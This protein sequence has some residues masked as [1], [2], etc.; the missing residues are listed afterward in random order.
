LE[1]E[2][3]VNLPVLGL[4]LH[5]GSPRS[6]KPCRYSVVVIRNGK[7]TLEKRGVQLNEILRIASELG[8]CIL[9]TDNVFE[10]APDVSGLR[11]LFLKLPSGAKIIQVNK[12]GAFFERLSHVAR[13]EGLIV[14]KRSDSLVEAKLAALLA[15]RGVGSEVILFE[16]ECR[17]VVT[18]N[19]SIKKGGSGTN[20]WRRMIEAA[21]LNE[22]NRI[23]SCLDERG[24][25]YDLYVHQAEGGLRRAEFVVYAPE[26]TVTE[27]VRPRENGSIKV[28]ITRKMKRKLEFAGSRKTTQSKPL[29]VSIDPGASLG[30]AI[31]D[32]EGNVISLQTLRMPSR[33]Q[34]IE[35]IVKHGRPVLITTDVF[36]IPERVKEIA[37]IF[38]AKIEPA[39]D[40][41]TLKEKEKVVQEFEES[42]G[43]KASTSHERDALAALLITYR[44]LNTL[45]KKAEARAR[46]KGVPFTTRVRELL[47]KG[48]SISEALAPEEKSE[49]LE[50]RRTVKKIRRRRSPI[51]SELLKRIR[52]LEDRLSYYEELLQKKEKEISGLL[53]QISQLREKINL[54]IERDRRIAQRDARIRELEQELRK[55]RWKNELLAAKVKELENVLKEPPTGW[56]QVLVLNKLSREV[57]EVAAAEKRIREGDVLLVIDAS[58]MGKTVVGMLSEL[59][60]MALIW[61]RNPPPVE[62]I[63]ELESRGINV[64]CG[65]DIEIWWRGGIPY[66]KGDI[67]MRDSTTPEHVPK[68]GGVRLEDIL[69][70]YRSRIIERE[71]E[72]EER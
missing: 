58:G 29:L 31:S 45:F 56:I 11:R 57:I 32:L 68:K 55:A 9:A 5:S 69:R 54:E 6:S 47:V 18:R 24:I 12:E 71:V 25:E 27:I 51:A 61:K 23:A 28:M 72:E 10:L 38:N 4:D 53:E 3:Q 39:A 22:A 15:S 63:H 19:A 26:P 50:Q 30:L 66:I 7:V 49:H 36:P 17:I 1:I 37:K 67:L 70:E 13:K 52:E 21:I 64:I 33:S 14:G 62:V 60:V 48:K 2:K 44:R 42:S 8:P 35:E 34:I 16:P 65:R 59:G 41:L 20:R 40:L 46:E 43:L